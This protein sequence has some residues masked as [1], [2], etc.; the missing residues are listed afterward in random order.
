MPEEEKEESV[1]GEWHM[2]EETKEL[3]DTEDASL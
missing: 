3:P 2:E 1:D